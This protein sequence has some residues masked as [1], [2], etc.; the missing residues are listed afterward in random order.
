MMT[1]GETLLCGILVGVLLTIMIVAA[2]AVQ[3]RRRLKPRGDGERRWM[4][5]V[6]A[7]YD[8]GRADALELGVRRRGQVLKV[9]K[10]GQRGF[11]ATTRAD[12]VLSGLTMDDGKGAA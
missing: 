5:A 2:F 9:V 1:H 8:Q 4:K 12:G 10:R 11:V 6:E 3:P 7:A